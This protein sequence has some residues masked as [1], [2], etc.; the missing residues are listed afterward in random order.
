MY[1]AR[2]VTI[3]NKDTNEGGFEC[4]FELISMPAQIRHVFAFRGRYIT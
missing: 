2:K 3:P 1:S 4:P